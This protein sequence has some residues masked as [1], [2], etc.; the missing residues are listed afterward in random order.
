MKYQVNITEIAERD[1]RSIYEHIA[2]TLGSKIN[3]A[4]QLKRLKEEIFSLETMPESYRA[5]EKEPWHSR[6]LRVMRVDNYVVFYIP[7]EDRHTVEVIRV[8]YGG[9]DTDTQ[10]NQN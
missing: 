10:L 7:Y 6:G 4:G 8:M 5:Y 2:Y 9:R 1:L 3:A